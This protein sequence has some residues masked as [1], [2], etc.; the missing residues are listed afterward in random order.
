[1]YLLTPNA[2]HDRYTGKYFAIALLGFKIAL[3]LPWWYSGEES[4]CHCKGHRL[5]P[6]SGK[7]SHVMEQQSLVCH[8]Y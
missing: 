3:G 2:Q 5:N 1:M 6:W 7:M 8:S 4:A